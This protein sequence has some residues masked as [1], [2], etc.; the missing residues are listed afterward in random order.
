MRTI[1]KDFT[2]LASPRSYASLP[3][4]A[5]PFASMPIKLARYITTSS[6][7]LLKTY[8][9]AWCA[10]SSGVV[11]KSVVHMISLSFSWRGAMS[12][13]AWKCVQGWR[14]TINSEADMYS[15]DAISRSSPWLAE[16]DVRWF[17]KSLVKSWALWSRACPG[18]RR[19]PCPP[20]DFLVHFPRQAGRVVFPR[21]RYSIIGDAPCKHRMKAGSVVGTADGED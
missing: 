21:K 10:V 15:F 6:S 16:L 1:G 13:S 7:D 18:S 17:M 9:P 19:P 5:G 2:F 20:F 11:C 3:R 14:R 4:I 8:R 12:S